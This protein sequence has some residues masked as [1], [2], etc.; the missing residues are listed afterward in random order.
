MGVVESVPDSLKD[1][2]GDAYYGLGSIEA[3]VGYHDYQYTAEHGTAWAAAMVQLLKPQGGRVLDIGCANGTLLSKLPDRFERYGIEVNARMAALAAE[4]GAWMLGG[5]LLDP[6]LLREHSGR[7]DVVTSIAVFE[8][9]PDIRRGMQVALELL[10][11]DGVLLFEVPYISAEHNNDAW[12]KSSLEHVYYPSGKSIRCLVEGLDAYL[13]GGEVYAQ[14]FASIYIGIAFRDRTQA[15]KLQSLFNSLTNLCVPAENGAE[16]RARQTL[17]LV[18]AAHSNPE[19]VRGWAGWPGVL[20]NQHLL[21][22]FEQLWSDD[23]R[24]LAASHEECDA[25]AAARDWHAAQTAQ[26]A[27]LVE[28]AKVRETALRAEHDA[29][30]SARDRQA[31]QIAEQT[32]QIAEQARHLK[33]AAERIAIMSNELEALRADHRTGLSNM[34]LVIEEIQTRLAETS[35]ERDTLQ[36]QLVAILQSTSWKIS[37]PLRQF[38]SRHQNSARLL[39][40]VGKLIWW[41]A[42]WELRERL[43]EMRQRRQVIRAEASQAS[44]VQPDDE[45]ALAYQPHDEMPMPRCP[46]AGP[47]TLGSEDDPEIW[48][49]GQPLVTVVIP[50]FNSGRFLTEAVDSVLSQTF[51]DLE[52]IVVE[53]GSTDPESRRIALTMDKPRVRVIAQAHPHIVGGIRNF[54]ISQALG[55]YVCCLDADDKLA[56]TYIEKA[57]YLLEEYGYDVVSTATRFFG[58]RTDRVGILAAPTLTDMMEANHL[59][60]CAVFR[61]SLW[62]RAGGFRDM[63]PPVTGHVNEDWMFWLRLAG[64]GARMFNVC[65]ESLFLHRNHEAST[66][67]RPGLFSMPVHRALVLEANADVINPDAIERSRHNAS[68][69]RRPGVSLPNLLTHGPAGRGRPVLLLALPFTLI[70][71]AERLLSSIVRYLSDRGWRVLVTTSIDPGPGHGDTTEWFEAATKEIY[72]LPRFLAPERWEGFLRYLIASRDVDIL[73]IVGSAFVYDSLPSILAEFPR[74]RVADLLFNPV[75]HTR[76]NRKHA[77][78]ISLNFVENEEVRRFL[79]AAGEAQEHIALCPSGVDLDEHCPGPRD[80]EVV[81]IT[82]AAPEDLMVGFSGRFAEEK[83]P[84]AFVEI[85]RRVPGDLPVRFVMTGTGALRESVMEAVRTAAFP[86]GRFCLAGPVPDVLPWLRSYDVLVLPSRLDG[87]PVVALEALACGVPVVASHVGGLPDL[88]EE[89]MTGFLCP[90]GDVDAFAERITRLVRNRELLAQMKIAAR[91]YAERNLDAQIMLRHYEELL[92][93]LLP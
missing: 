62:R 3:Q 40:R 7:F 47:D 89:G 75:G 6:A 78:L 61:R 5:D 37:A 63:H 48:P 71:G 12:F 39:R 65:C 85:A 24:R 88:V 32:A 90:P 52:V 54:G 77:R 44:A 30:A 21:Q 26:Q 20:L 18:H 46:S 66:T 8:H 74:L 84:L 15:G 42:R 50:C 81:R 87:R 19:L 23:L 92:Q 45:P 69:D 9:L 79:L 73:W 57:V 22:R 83:D 35:A 93:G 2:Y 80:P 1:Y 13:V 70:G 38:G 67:Q 76:N 56:P 41:T 49:I 59:V 55:K 14:D 86:L 72:H 4:R 16:Q 60:T 43:R 64:L 53:G 34:A 11:S 27:R 28:D 91:Q 82:G 29:I 58:A 33:E 31:V 51:T 36:A 68:E 17:L 25:I 10:S